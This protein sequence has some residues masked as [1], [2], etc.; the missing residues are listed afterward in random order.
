MSGMP[1]IKLYKGIPVRPIAAVL[2]LMAL[3]ACQQD[4]AAVMS[5]PEEAV[6]V[7]QQDFSA[8]RGSVA[9]VRTA[10]TEGNASAPEAPPA[11]PA[12]PSQITDTPQQAM[13]IKNGNATIEVDSLEIALTRVTQLAQRLGGV[14]A[15]SSIQTGR[16]EVRHAS[17]VLRIPAA[18]FDD[19][20]DGLSP[21]GK[22]ESQNVSS[23]DV[24]EQFVDMTAR[25][26]NAK[27]LE[28]RLINLL[29]TR[30]GKLSDVLAIE[31]ELAR[32]REEIERYE[33]QLRYL[34]TRAAIS[35]LTLELHEK[36][37]IINPPGGSNVI[38]QAF[39]NAWRNFVGFVAGT[40]SALGVLIPLILVGLGIVLVLRRLGMLPTFRRS[41]E[42][43]KSPP[44]A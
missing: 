13:I 29:A 2:V 20:M 41:P 43:P 16:R 10:P 6:S 44:E 28:E 39:R 22:V 38:V 7:A 42:P 33:G 27:R 32:V 17:V 8:R 31:R 35:T 36:F 24:T 19:A 4:K 30:T 26:K 14:V 37:P 25:A 5:A 3:V 9:G 18:R 1:G 34:R 15:N 12:M 21:I 11:P 40:I 23:E